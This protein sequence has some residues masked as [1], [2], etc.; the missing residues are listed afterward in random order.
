MGLLNDLTNVE[1][2]F[3]LFI[4]DTKSVIKLFD[5]EE[6]AYD[7][8]ILFPQKS[9]GRIILATEAQLKKRSRTRSDLSSSARFCQ[10]RR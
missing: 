1:R 8:A 10:C 2:G 3:E 9:K 4:R 6:R 7:H 5:L